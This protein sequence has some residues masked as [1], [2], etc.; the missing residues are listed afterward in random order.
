MWPLNLGIFLLHALMVAIFVAIP[1]QLSASGLIAEHHSWLYLPVL[2]VA[3]ILMVP[4]IIIAEKK[5]RMKGVVLTGALIIALSLFLMSGASQLWHWVVLLLLYFWGFNLMEASLPSWL[6]K[7]APAG[8]KGSA[9]GVYSTMQFLGAF[10]GGSVGGWL[11]QDYGLSILFVGLGALVVLW[12]L[13]I[14]RSG[15]PQHLTSVRLPADRISDDQLSALSS[16]PGVAESLYLQS[17]QAI[18]LKVS[19]DSFDRES[20]LKIIDSTGEKHGSQR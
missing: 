6:S 14:T 5:R 16:L 13:L 4:L 1:G 8:S 18:Y 17:E 12:A 11:L 9:M 7:I 10:A 19:A 15:A 2:I 20:A 3:F